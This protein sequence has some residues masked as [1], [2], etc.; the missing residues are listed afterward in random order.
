MFHYRAT[1]ILLIRN[2]GYSDQ[3]FIAT[4]LDISLTSEKLFVK[5]HEAG[6]YMQERRDSNAEGNATR[7]DRGPSDVVF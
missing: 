2:L 5:S 1:A 6:L 3:T 4:D 7:E